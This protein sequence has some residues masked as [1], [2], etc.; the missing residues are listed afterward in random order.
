M[1]I[2]LASGSTDQ[3]HFRTGIEQ[4]LMIIPEDQNLIRVVK[5]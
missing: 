4:F 2:R 3:N 5:V 1:R